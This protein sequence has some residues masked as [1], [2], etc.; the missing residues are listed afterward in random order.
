MNQSFHMNLSLDELRA[1]P[2]V[3]NALQC[4]GCYSDVESDTQRQQSMMK[5]TINNK[6][7]RKP[8]DLTSCHK[9]LRSPF[10]IA[11][12]DADE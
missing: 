6:P 9:C 10:P 1:S 2:S 8:S 5:P 4:S 7:F 12:N 11:E 3:H